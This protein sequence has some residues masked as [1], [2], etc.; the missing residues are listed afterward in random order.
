MSRRSQ[1]LLGI[2]L[3]LAGILC[4]VAGSIGAGRGVDWLAEGAPFPAGLLFALAVVFLLRAALTGPA[5]TWAYFSGPPADDRPRDDTP[6]S[7]RTLE[8]PTD[9]DQDRR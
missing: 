9:T 6:P 5:R 4:A 3:L 2:G 8:I 7:A 1:A